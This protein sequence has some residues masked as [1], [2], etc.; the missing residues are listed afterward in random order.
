MWVINYENAWLLAENF[1]FHIFFSSLWYISPWLFD[2]KAQYSDL[3][4]DDY[5]N[6]QVKTKNV[7]KSHPVIEA[8]LAIKHFWSNGDVAAV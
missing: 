5:I 4:G 7:F 1:K 2:R 6:L 3:S 8:K